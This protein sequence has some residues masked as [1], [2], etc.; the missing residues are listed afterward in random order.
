MA[1]TNGTFVAKM[2]QAPGDPAPAVLLTLDLDN[3]YTADGYADFKATVLAAVSGQIGAGDIDIVH[4]GQNNS[5]GSAGAK[6][7]AMY[8]RT[9]DKLVCY[10]FA[11][12]EHAG[13]ADLSSVVGLELVI[14]YK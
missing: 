14:W 9:N 11:G 3:N 12:A 8:D 10:D 2:G 6:T 7:L 13:A 5:P 4:V 1:I